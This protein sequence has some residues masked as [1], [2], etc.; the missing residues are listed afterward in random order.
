MKALWLGL[1]LWAWL[2]ACPAEA[3][4]EELLGAMEFGQVQEMIDGMLGENSFS[5]SEAVRKLAG[6]KEAFSKEAVQ[7]F[8]RCLL[9]SRIE[10][11]KSGFLKLLLLILL[12]ALFSNFAEVFENGQVG[13]VSFYVV[14]L[15]LFTMLMETFSSL[16]EALSV[17][18]E[19]LSG[20]MRL[21]S[22]AYFLA[23]AAS[24]GASTAAVFYEGVLLLVWM[25]EWLLL[26]FLLPGVSL[27]LLLKL[28]NHLSREEM[29]SKMAE[30]IETGIS[31]SLKTLLGFAAGLQAVRNLI[32]PVMDSLKR[33]AA[34]RTAGAIPG[35][36]NAVNAV[37]ELVL[38][39]AVL[40]RNSLGVVTLL[41]LAL[42]SLEPVVHYALLSFAYRFLAALSQPVS[43]RR[44]VGALGTM[45]EACGLLLKI[46][47]TAEALC[48]LTLLVVMSGLGGGR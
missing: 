44:M 2:C 39:S 3:A 10:A 45:G 29:L 26:H 7:E 20:F 38:T 37:T 33:T 47:L 13:A 43:D 28:V 23:V 11:E 36:G 31:W 35:I 8:L 17:N 30:L 5:F 9:F 4:E 27:Y 21:L 6:G 32:A 16:S 46:L 41:A 48:M 24:S 18:L 14:Y 34:G 40:V 15:L 42:V 12:A 19:W 22:P 25:I 1:L